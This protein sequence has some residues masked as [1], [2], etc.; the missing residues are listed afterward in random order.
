MSVIPFYYIFALIALLCVLL[1]AIAVLLVYARRLREVADIHR[2]IKDPHQ[3]ELLNAMA[4][5]LKNEEFSLRFQPIISLKTGKI[6]GVESLVRWE[7][8][9]FGMIYPDAFISLAE[10][11]GLI[12]PLGEWILKAACL[13]AKNLHKKGFSHVRV[14]VNLSA[15]QFKNSDVVEQIASLC[16]DLQV[17]PRMLEVELTESIFLNNSQKNLL[18]LKVLREM[19]VTIS[20]DDFG[21]G[22][23]SLKYLREFPLDAL[24]IDKA[25][26]RNINTSE[27][28]KNIVKAMLTLGK[29]L[30]MKT[31]AEGVETI[32]EATLLAQWGADELQG[33][34]FYKPMT[35]EQLHAE[36]HA[37]KLKQPLIILKN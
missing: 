9:K 8:P 29:A 24:K 14:A 21:T 15:E 26:I 4:S 13:Q 27:E 3:R 20:L 35:E 1:L 37:Q 23:S 31:I 12:M 18:M 11:S 5:G 19:G 7:H 16:D 6:C 2:E 28:S 25:F 32:E 36:L 30:H 34:Y 10:Q 33:Y 17:S 22:Y